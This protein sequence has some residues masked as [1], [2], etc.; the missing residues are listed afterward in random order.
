M[1][2]VVYL[3]RASEAVI[4]HGK[5]EGY[6]LNHEHPV[7]QHKARVFLSALGIDHCNWQYLRDRLLAGAVSTPV[8]GTRMT[9]YG[10]VYDMVVLVDG[11]NGA[12]QPVKM[13]WMVK[14]EAPPRL[15]SAWVDIP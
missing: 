10:V 11:L 15:V 8:Q 6:V 1:A 4:P 12:T 7:G 2:E 13:I 3:P 14:P 5:L 9:P